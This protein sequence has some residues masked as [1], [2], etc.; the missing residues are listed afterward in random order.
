M[1]PPDK[2]RGRPGGRAA[3]QTS[4]DGDATNLPAGTDR[5][6]MARRSWAYAMVSRCTSPPP[7][8]GS[9]E[10]MALTDGD[11]RKVAAV[12]NA[13]ECWA[14]QGD[15]LEENLRAEVAALRAAH[16]ANDDADYVARREQHR[17]EWK[18]L[19]LVRGMAY[20]DTDEFRNGA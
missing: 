9:P 20:A 18:H 6:M 14:R 2:D 17:R 8:Y 4:C 5:R 1:P 16:K 3:S 7:I 15:E 12:V 10:W 19:R 11:V 13:A